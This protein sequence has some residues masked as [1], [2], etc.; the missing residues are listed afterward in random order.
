MRAAPEGGGVFPPAPGN[1]AL[2]PISLIRP[3]RFAGTSPGSSP[4][5]GSSLASGRRSRAT[6]P[7]LVW[8]VMVI[9]VVPRVTTVAG[10]AA[11][12]TNG[13]R[14]HRR[15]HLWRRG[16]PGRQRNEARAGG[17]GRM[18]RVEIVQVRVHRVGAQRIPAVV[19]RAERDRPRGADRRE[20]A[21]RRQLGHRV[22]VVEDAARVRDAETGERDAERRVRRRGARRR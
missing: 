3:H 14:R 5:A 15:L 8:I 11:A 18:R 2:T 16:A 13:R 21:Q 22:P 1:R 9:V 17:R 4:G 19:R 10:A 12:R 6:Y 20:A 7:S